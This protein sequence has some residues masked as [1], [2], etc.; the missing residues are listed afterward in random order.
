MATG[1]AIGAV[2]YSLPRACTATVVNGVTYER[3]D[4]VWYRPSYSGNQVVYVVVDAPR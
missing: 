4:G 3:C 2:V 1:A